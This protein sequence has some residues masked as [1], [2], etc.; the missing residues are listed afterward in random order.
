[1]KR[2]AVVVAG[3]LGLFIAAGLI[4]PALAKVR[5]HGSMP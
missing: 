2:I 5:D 4:L 3:L 1:M